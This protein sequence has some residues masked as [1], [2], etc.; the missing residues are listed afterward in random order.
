MKSHKITSVKVY[1]LR[2]Y[3][4]KPPWRWKYPPPT[5]V[6]SR[7]N[8]FRWIQS[9]FADPMPRSFFI[10]SRPPK[11]FL[12]HS[13]TQGGVEWTL[14]PSP[15]NSWMATSI[16]MKYASEGLSRNL[17]SLLLLYCL[18]CCHDKP[19]K[20]E[21]LF[22]DFLAL[23]LKFIIKSLIHGKLVNFCRLFKSCSF[24]KH[25]FHREGEP[26]F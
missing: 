4:Q 12:I 18:R 7:L 26:E 10:N 5:L 20:L 23:F 8:P 25:K 22:R 2:S 15:P 6:L 1:C 13:L 24:Q 17:L 21:V 14:P 16:E 9:Q 19:W 3:Q 11:V